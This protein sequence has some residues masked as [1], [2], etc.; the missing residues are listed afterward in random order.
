MKIKPENSCGCK[1]SIDVIVK[2]K[3]SSSLCTLTLTTFTKFGQTFI[4]VYTKTACRNM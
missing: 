1:T 2:T 3:T 4:L